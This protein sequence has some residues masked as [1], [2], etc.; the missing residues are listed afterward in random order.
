VCMKLR[1]ALLFG[2]ALGG[3]VIA[4]CTNGS[5]NASPGSENVSAG[6]NE[7]TSQ[8]GLMLT[9]PGGFTIS[10][11]HIVI[12]GPTPK[13]FDQNVSTASG[14]QQ[15]DGTVAIN[16]GTITGLAP[17]SY[18]VT[19]SAVSVDGS[20]T[21]TGAAAPFTVTANATATVTAFASCRTPPS[22]AGEG[23]IIG[24]FSNCG[25]VTSLADNIGETT[26]GDTILVNASA[27]APNMAALTW[28]FS[29]TPSDGT[30]APATGAGA[31]PTSTFTCTAAGT[32]T[33]TVTVADGT[34]PPG[35]PPCSDVDTKS[36]VVV[37]DAPAT[38]SDAGI[39]TGFE[40]PDTGFEGVDTG[41]DVKADVCVAICPPGACGVSDGCG[42]TCNPISC[43]A[44]HCEA[45]NGG[46]PCTET[47]LLLI[48]K[49]TNADGTPKAAGLTAFGCYDCLVG[50]G[51]LDD[52]LFA[53]DVDHEC[54]DTDANG[55]TQPTLS[56]SDKTKSCWAVLAC[57]LGGNCASTLGAG[58]CYCGTAVGSNCNT[59][60]LPNGTCLTQEQDGT[61]TTTPA[62]VNNRFTNITY[63]AGMANTILSCAASNSCTQCFP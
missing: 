17:G 21:C 18:T 63:A 12:S 50:A 44:S 31:A 57:V 49:D 36:M 5:G 6:S 27:T 20:V 40:G 34:V 52:K 22:D 25:R 19:I 29:A 56:G 23:T 59:A 47:E 33:I 61:D 55:I 58:T 54:E 9:L 37:C 13:T 32:V 46:Q 26:V 10:T 7:A 8:V 38:T 16:L 14:V 42:G 1:H 30:F 41:T 4:A 51:C 35:A 62:T 45:N 48:G 2:L 43:N 11:V 24:G 53:S 60:G 28:A 15:P 39:D 3:S